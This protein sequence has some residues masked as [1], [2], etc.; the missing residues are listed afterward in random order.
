MTLTQEQ[1][2]L[3]TVIAAL[4][5]LILGGFYLATLDLSRSI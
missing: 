5:F 1:L 3:L 4:L 2:R